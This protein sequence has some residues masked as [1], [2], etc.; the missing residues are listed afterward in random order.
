V[1][2]QLALLT[3][4]AATA[5]NPECPLL[6]LLLRRLLQAAVTQKY[7]VCR[8]R[9]AATVLYSV[10]GMRGDTT[11]TAASASE[12]AEPPAQQLVSLVRVCCM[13]LLQQP[14]NSSAAVVDAACDAEADG[15]IQQRRPCLLLL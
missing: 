14:F 2:V 8:V 7:G 9:A 6:L 1:P 4:A 3:A 12:K 5:P 10:R 11:P 15:P 13:Q